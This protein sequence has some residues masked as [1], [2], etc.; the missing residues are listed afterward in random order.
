MSFGVLPV[1]LTAL[2]VTELDSCEFQCV[3]CV[4]DR[5]VC[6]RAGQLSDR[7]SVV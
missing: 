6:D 1:L 3:A 5:V 4:A 7:K 2:C